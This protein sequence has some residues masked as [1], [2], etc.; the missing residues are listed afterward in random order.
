MVSPR[1]LP[2]ATR[3]SLNCWATWGVVPMIGAT[4]ILLEP[5]NQPPAPLKMPPLLGPP[6]PPP[7]PDNEASAQAAS[8]TDAM[9]LS[10]QRT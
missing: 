2:A 5:P 7:Q 1:S 4:A 10:Q 9:R 8:A 3:A 6:G